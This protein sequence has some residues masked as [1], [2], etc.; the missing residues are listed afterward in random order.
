M[1]E[2]PQQPDDSDD[3]LGGQGAPSDGAPVDDVQKPGTPATG[4]GTTPQEPSGA[5]T[6]DPS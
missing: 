1:T 5:Q 2:T 4:P 6:Q 3:D